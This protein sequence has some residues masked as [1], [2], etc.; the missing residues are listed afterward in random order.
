MRERLAYFLVLTLTFSLVS[1]CQGQVVTQQPETPAGQGSLSAAA[2]MSSKRAAH[3]A[4]LLDSGKVLIAGGFVGS[5]GGLSSSE[6]FDPARGVFVPAPS[7]S[8]ARSGH[9]AT[10]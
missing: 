9:T 8:A 6:L 4:T 7:M 5:G 10:R 3:T 2:S 1:A